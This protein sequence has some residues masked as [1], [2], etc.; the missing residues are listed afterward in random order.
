MSMW[1]TNLEDV[2]VVGCLPIHFVG[3]CIVLLKCLQCLQRT[4]FH[5][6]YA[7]NLFCFFTFYF[8]VEKR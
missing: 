2:G 4:L 1:K 5:C 3:G 6:T 7:I 8:A